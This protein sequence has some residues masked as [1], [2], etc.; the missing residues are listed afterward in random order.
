[1]TSNKIK[2]L[3]LCYDEINTTESLQYLQELQNIA[4]EKDDVE[5]IIKHI[6]TIIYKE[7]GLR[8]QIKDDDDGDGGYYCLQFNQITVNVCFRIYYQLLHKYNLKDE[9][10]AQYIP[11]RCQHMEKT[12]D[13]F[14]IL[15]YVL[16][17]GPS[18][19]L[20][21]EELKNK[22]LEAFAKAVDNND[23]SLLDI[24]KAL[25][26]IFKKW[27]HLDVGNDL[28][29]DHI[30][31][32]LQSNQL[33]MRD[34][35]LT[36]LQS[37]CLNSERALDYFI[38]VVNFWPWTYRT[39]IYM[40]MS[41]LNKNSL[42]DLLEKSGYSE[43]EFFKGIRSTLCYKNLLPSSQHVVKAL[44]AQ[45]S[46]ALLQ[47]CLEILEN[48]SLQ[49]IRNLHAQWFS[50]IQQK[51]ELFQM[52]WKNMRMRDTFEKGIFMQKDS[53]SNYRFILICSMF[54]KEIYQHSSQYFA[55][56]SNEL[57]KNCFAYDLETQLLLYKFVVDNLVIVDIVTCMEFVTL[58]S[59]NHVTVEN[60]QFRNT[61]LGK[62]PM[63]INHI[64]KMFCRLDKKD[65]AKSPL[66]NSILTFFSQIQYDIEEGIV[67]S[68]YQ[69]KIF[70][71]KL[72]EILINSLYREN[73]TKN[74]KNCCLKQN[75]I[76][77]EFLKRHQLFNG[78]KVSLKLVQLLNDPTGFDDALELMV[79]L[80]GMI[81]PLEESLI[82]QAFE[83]SRICC[84]LSDVDESN[85][86]C[87]YAR[88]VVENCL[89]NERI[90]VLFKDTFENIKSKLIPFQD[91]PLY[92]CK[93]NG[94]H[95]FSSLNVINELVQNKAKL[96]LDSFHS[97]QQTIEEIE[98]II[99][100][101]LNFC[102][103]KHDGEEIN[104]A[105][106]EDMD[107]SLEILVESSKCPSEN[108][109]L[110]RKYMLMSFWL[111]LKACCDLA[112]SMGQYIISSNTQ[113]EGRLSFIQRNIQISVNV[114]TKCRHKGAIE[115]AGV[116]I[117]KLTKAITLNLSERGQ[118]YDILHKCLQNLYED[119]GKDSVSTTR[120]GAGFSI[121]FLHIVKNEANRSRPLL[122]KAMKSL[123][124]APSTNE[125]HLGDFSSNCDRSE[126]LHLHYLCVLVR[127][128]EL[129]EAMAK[130]H[131]EIMMAAVKHIDNP[132]WTIRNGALQLLGALV[133][134]IVG[135]RQ[136]TEFEESLLW[137]PSEVTFCEVTRKL[138]K[139]FAYILEYCLAEKA[140]TGSI[141]LFLEFLH[142]VEYIHKESMIVPESV[143]EFRKLIWI[144]LRHPCEKVRILSSKCFVRSHEFSHELPNA[145]KEIA[146]ILFHV[147]NENF[148]EG[149]IQTLY[150][151]VL[152][153]QHDF[154]YVLSA[155]DQ[156]NI[157][158]EIK[159]ALEQ[160]FVLT[161]SYKFY[162]LC[163][164][165]D[166]LELLNFDANSMVLQK[167]RHIQ[168]NCNEYPIAYDLWLERISKM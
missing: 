101:M 137:E 48:G 136:A 109:E 118:E 57:M 76:L 64:A 10:F 155:M 2:K 34:E 45:R 97:L 154:K 47:M 144:L 166:L 152:K 125:N 88:V 159:D 39:K 70:S 90:M 60:A 124:V 20:D 35:M 66:A 104:A 69:P 22:S 67:R 44:S 158:L 5:H 89:E 150:H 132:E 78:A 32:C 119:S 46:Q 121:M 4:L 168:V 42:R 9:Y 91:D 21:P 163:K 113:M 140:A 116:T 156:Q 56:L 147:K 100:K 146:K 123:L 139:S 30:Y 103:R 80:I 68:V 127:D 98:D 49:E 13:N 164:L 25:N 53:L 86:S 138:D 120:R 85:L 59:R 33:G 65:L 12:D 135:Q 74:S 128:T 111:T 160:H 51:D 117:G 24:L 38:R 61:I 58:F 31:F 141:I 27:P 1:M 153:L 17:T 50:R 161:R 94:G 131:N 87:L 129:R 73:V 26:L 36:F 71:L 130:Y 14:I 6:K 92:V 108:H 81:E 142:K 133:P 105:S 162:T 72:L 83:R 29:M 19:D 8:K 122:R 52:I 79:K 3:P 110:S 151:G 84:S 165:W 95:L 145:L 114:L 75:Q 43:T 106:F 96:L 107:K 63:I 148:F 62:M 7:L 15:Y 11:G 41:I 149:L 37:V 99:L 143:Q 18:K 77:A 40:L 102:N 134:K 82:T 28:S 54:P 23:L 157:L 167:L 126:A 16:L 112:A 115:A 55:T 93:M